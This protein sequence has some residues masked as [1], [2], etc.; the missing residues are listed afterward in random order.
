ME[1]ESMDAPLALVGD[2]FNGNTVDHAYCSG[3]KLA[4]HWVKKFGN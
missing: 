2:Y 1:I 3:L 4:Q